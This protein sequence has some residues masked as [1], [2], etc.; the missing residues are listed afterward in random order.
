M[1]LAQSFEEIGRPAQ[2]LLP[3]NRTKQAR[4]VRHRQGFEAAAGLR[5][6]YYWA[7][8]GR[9]FAHFRP[10]TAKSG[11]ESVDH[12]QVG[13]QPP[14]SGLFALLSFRTNC[15]MFAQARVREDQVQRLG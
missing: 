6:V 8:V 15:E 11:L 13:V 14:V 7:A 2:Q 3:G 9:H 4:P 1:A 5:I 12:L 10:S